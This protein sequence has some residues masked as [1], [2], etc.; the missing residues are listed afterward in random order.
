[1]ASRSSKTGRYSRRAPQVASPSCDRRVYG[2]AEGSAP[3]LSLRHRVV[4]CRH[5]FVSFSD[6]AGYDH[7][8]LNESRFSSPPV[9]RDSHNAQIRTRFRSH[10]NGLRGSEL[11]LFR[12]R[13]RTTGLAELADQRRA[14]T[15]TRVF[16]SAQWVRDV[17]RG[18]IQ[19]VVLARICMLWGY[20]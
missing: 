1:M 19:V 6:G 9:T 18:W 8:H 10:F 12:F 17:G 5:P 13:G 7:E 20:K 16:L 14:T 4:L 2:L 11:S 3:V 15:L